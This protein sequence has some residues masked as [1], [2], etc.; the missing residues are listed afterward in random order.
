MLLGDENEEYIQ[1]IVYTR[2]CTDIHK[3]N[4]MEM[5]TFVTAVLDI[6]GNN[7]ATVLYPAK[8]NNIK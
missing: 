6:R 7:L 5:L 8:T 1:Y 4:R 2:T 3:R